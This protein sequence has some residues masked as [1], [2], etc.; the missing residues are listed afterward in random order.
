M[1]FFSVK[2]C[3]LEVERMDHIL[4]ESFK[5]PFSQQKICVFFLLFFFLL[6]SWMQ[7][8]LGKKG[9]KEIDIMAVQSLAPEMLA[10]RR[11]LS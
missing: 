3:E 4:K 2:S 10:P 5:C 7:V 6:H 9:D 1:Y 11:F 8:K